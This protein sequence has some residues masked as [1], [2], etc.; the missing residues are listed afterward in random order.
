[1]PCC[2]AKGTTCCDAGVQCDVELCCHI[3]MCRFCSTAHKQGLAIGTACKIPACVAGCPLEVAICDK[4]RATGD[5]LV[6]LQQ[7]AAALLGGRLSLAITNT[8]SIATTGGV[9]VGLLFPTTTTTTFI[10]ALPGLKSA[11]VHLRCLDAAN[12]AVRVCLCV[13]CPR[14]LAALPRGRKTRCMFDV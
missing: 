6:L 9:G 1:M 12:I 4:A 7:H 3:T 11:P 5:Q 10:P 14:V 13:T 2:A 8:V